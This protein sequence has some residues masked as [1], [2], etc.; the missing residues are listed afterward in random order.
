MRWLR[1]YG[2]SPLV[3]R[4]LVIGGWCGLIWWVSSRSH[5]KVSLNPGGQ[6]ALEE[7]SPVWSFVG[8]G[9]HVVVFGIL[10]ALIFLLLR[11]RNT[12][13]ALLAIVLSSAYGWLDEWHQSHVLGRHSSI[14]DWA[15]DT[16]G[17]AL[18]CAGLIWLLQDSVPARRWVFILIP[19]SLSSVAIETFWS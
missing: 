15:S 1:R 9:A 5:T 4:F 13:R 8:N 16:C 6:L 2:Q 7:D 3:I 14:W 10:A 19:L 11:G 12:L 18:F 17:S